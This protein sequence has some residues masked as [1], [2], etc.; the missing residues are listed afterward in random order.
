MARTARY[1]PIPDSEWPETLADMARGFAGQ[2]NVY[3]TMAHNPELLRAW[4]TLRQHVVMN[5]ALGP[6]RSEVVILRTGVRLDSDYEWFQHIRRARKLG[7][8]DSRIRSI[9]GPLEDMAGDDSALCRAVDELFAD[10]RLSRA[11]R[12]TLTSLLGREAVLDLLATVGFY[13]TLGF[14]L[15]SFDTP[16]DADAAAELDAQPLAG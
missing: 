10:R 16:L 7:F 15:N 12:E 1:D 3:R 5:S 11:S 4:S 6:E 13:S 2:L 9:E 8:S 14:I